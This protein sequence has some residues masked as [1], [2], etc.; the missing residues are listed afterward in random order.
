VKFRELRLHTDE[1]TERAGRRR[2]HSAVIVD[3]G[4]RCLVA[5][6]AERGAETLE[7]GPERLGRP[8]TRLSGQLAAERDPWR[9]PRPDRL[10]LGI[11][12]G[13]RDAVAP[14]KR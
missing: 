4:E 6:A 14:R 3:F 7:G 5:E 13:G 8:E 12:R 11:P 1:W 2:F 10:E 9:D